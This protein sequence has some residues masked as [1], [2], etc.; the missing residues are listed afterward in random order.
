MVGHKLTREMHE[1][2]SML[3]K[4]S[5]KGPLKAIGMGDT[6]VGMTLLHHLQIPY[7]STYKPNFK[8]IT[9]SARRGTKAKDLNRVNL[10][11]KVPDWNLSACKS[12]A[13][14]VEKYGYEREDGKK[15]YCTVNSRQPNSQGLILEV[16]TGY[17]LL[18]E[19]HIKKNA[20][21]DQ[22]A[23]WRLDVLEK[24]LKD[25]HKSSVWVIAVPSI[26]G[27][28]EYFH[29]RYATFTSNPKISMFANLIE[30]GTITMDHL[31]WKKLARVVEKGPLFKIKPE[32]VD[33]LF[34]VAAK[35]DLFEL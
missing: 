15:L 19:N 6:S 24:K 22:V 8:G 17:G 10:F 20:N 9:I 13:E 5:S 25:N 31:I 28:E 3:A 33:S 7:S 14:I 1:L 27:G 23:I 35:V 12:S 30:Q 11:A 2:A 4:L 16:D 29:F 32:N 34:P 26:K 18:Y 21:K